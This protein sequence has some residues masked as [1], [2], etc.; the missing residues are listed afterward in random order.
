MDD[1]KQTIDHG[2]WTIGKNRP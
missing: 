1:D 2:R